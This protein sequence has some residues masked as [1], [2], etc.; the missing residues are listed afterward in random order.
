MSSQI[1]LQA[2]YQVGSATWMILIRPFWWMT[3]KRNFS[4]QATRFRPLKRLWYSLKW[5]SRSMSVKDSHSSQK[6]TTWT[7]SRL[8][9]SQ[10]RNTSTQVLETSPS[11]NERVIAKSSLF[12]VSNSPRAATANRSPRVSKKSLSALAPPIREAKMASLKSL[13]RIFATMTLLMT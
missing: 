2:Y 5:L 4:S 6:G 9:K 11:S 7:L 10:A 12:L 1:K 8:R 13:S 3:A